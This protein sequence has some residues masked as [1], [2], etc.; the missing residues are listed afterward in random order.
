M[1]DRTIRILHIDDDEA[2]ARLVQKSLGRAG[3]VVEHCA[4]AE[5]GMAR[6]REGGIDAVV[7]DHFLQP[8]TGIGVLDEMKSLP[9][10]PPV[11]YVTASA[12]PTVAV[13]ALKAGAT[14]YVLKTVGE[15][16]FVLLGSA[17][18]QSIETARLQRAKAKAEQEMRAARERAEILLAEVNHRVANSLAL[19]AALV[20][21]QATA[22]EDP[23]AKDALAET[24]ARIS[25]IANLHRRLYT[26]DDIRLV[27]LDEYIGSLVQELEA[28][29]QAA[30]HQPR[31]RL[32]LETFA[33]PTDK[34]VSVGMIITELLT[35][36]YKYAYAPDT[37]GEVRVLLERQQE[38][39]ARLV[40]E[41]DGIGW[42]GSGKPRGTGLGSRIV[43]AMAAN[44]GTE[45]TYGDGKRGTRAT[46]EI[47][48]EQHPG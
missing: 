39:S 43:Q 29:M 41:D 6:L 3:Y 1:P 8:G 35:N 36:A 15:E 37:N 40:V 24:Q 11:V 17:V 19:A 33:L 12:E 4:D 18:E 16:F 10:M 9:Q 48:V 34:A 13:D 46:M 5:S 20:R 31:T 2:L 23:T 25:A 30:G 45:I 28:S 21:M 38:G 22:I 42:S 27:H 7:L 47:T 14:D 26:S 32:Q 44:L